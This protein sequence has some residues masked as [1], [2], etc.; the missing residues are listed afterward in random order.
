MSRLLL[1]LPASALLACT[2]TARSGDSSTVDS[3]TNTDSSTDSTA[4]TD[5]ATPVENKIS[6]TY[7]TAAILPIQSGLWIGTPDNA[8]ETGG[9]PF[10]YLFSG[11]I[12][13]DQL[14]QGNGWLN[15]LPNGTQVMELLIGTTST[16]MGS[17]AAPHAGP[18]VAEINYAIAGGSGESRATA[19]NVALTSYTPDVWVEGTMT[20]TFPSGSASGTFHADWCATGRE[21]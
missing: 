1:L 7:G 14:S 21:I 12:T 3:A 13:C 6:G 16:S 8:N 11:P 10:V 9:G 4:D 5:T 17:P 19:G 18:G 2:S 20:A 15:T